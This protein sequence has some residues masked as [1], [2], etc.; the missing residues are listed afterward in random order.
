MKDQEFNYTGAEIECAIKGLKAYGLA[1]G[2]PRDVVLDM[3]SEMKTQI[4]AQRHAHLEPRASS[5][6]PKEEVSP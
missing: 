3:C 1:A 6:E 4:A 2:Y 5:S